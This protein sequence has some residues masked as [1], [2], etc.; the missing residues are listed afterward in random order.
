V[1][2]TV[3]GRSARRTDTADQDTADED[4]ADEEASAGSMTPVDA[5][6]ER[7]ACRRDVFVRE[8]H[9]RSR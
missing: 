7:D 1:V 4:T 6:S 8:G 9:G 2:L 3:V 5:L